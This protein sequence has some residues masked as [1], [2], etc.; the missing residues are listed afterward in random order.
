[1]YGDIPGLVYLEVHITIQVIQTPNTTFFILGDYEP[2][3]MDVIP[4]HNRSKHQEY[5]ISNNT[6]AFSIY[7]NAPTHGVARPGHLSHDE[8]KRKW[9]RENRTKET[10]S[11][12]TYLGYREHSLTVYLLAS[13]ARNR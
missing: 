9:A 2:T 6:D 8:Q 11:D 7:A 13:H 3:T 5:G 1:M 12:E 10:K 4:S